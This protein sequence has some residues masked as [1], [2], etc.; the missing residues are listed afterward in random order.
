MPGIR[1][2]SRWE[3]RKLIQ[4]AGFLVSS[5]ER[6]FQAAG[7][8]PGSG[9]SRLPGVDHMLRELARVAQHPPRDSHYTYWL[10]N[11]GG[12]KPLTF[13]GDP[14]EVFFQRAVCVTDWLHNASC[15]AVRPICQGYIPVASNDAA[16]ALHQAAQNTVTLHRHF[17][18]FMEKDAVEPTRRSMEPWFFMTRM[19]TYLPT[20]PI[21]GESWGGVNA[22]NLAAQMQ[23][24]YLIGTIDEKYTDIV[25]GRRRYLERVAKLL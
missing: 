19:R 18:A 11:T 4:L 12:D 1:Q 10:W 7:A 24:D 22:A 20:Y 21:Q 8:A 5:V 23:I 14:Q 6:H 9:L 25:Q 13:T 2:I 16:T 17:Q 3:A 15:D